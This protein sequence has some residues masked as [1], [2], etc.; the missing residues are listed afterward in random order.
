LKKVILLLI[1]LAVFT[2]NVLA[3]DTN[4]AFYP[5]FSYSDETG[6]MAGIISY[7][8]FRLDNF[9]TEIPKQDITTNVVYS[10]KKQFAFRFM[11]ILYSRDG[12]YQLEAKFDYDYWPTEFF[13]VGNKV[14]DIEPED[15][16]PQKINFDLR[17]KRRIKN[18]WHV[19]ALGEYFNSRLVKTEVGGEL[20]KKEILGSESYHLV[21]IGSGLVYDSRS[22]TSYPISGGI[23]DFSFKV[24]NKALGS[25]YNFL[26]FDLF[27]SKFVSL[28][29]K[30]VLAFTARTVLTNR[31]A[32]FQKLPH[33]GMYMRAYND[34][35]F[36]DQK[37][38]NFRTE[39]RAFPWSGKFFDRIGFVLF[40]D[41]GQTVAQIND[42]SLSD[43]KCSYGI[44]LRFS[45]FTDDRFN[46]RLD[47]G[48]CKDDSNFEISGGEAF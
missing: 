5:Q 10:A 8:R 4:F 14:Y 30:Q 46:L 44:G 6:F 25:D 23:M 11:P 20:E 19:L 41:A 12:L 2:T 48:F 16:T 28:D 39:Y 47:F 35:R 26:Q 13:G 18:N 7:F 45:V 27:G 34:T 24:Y 15:Y 31:N 9:P 43:M 21:G 22:S 38:I 3:K 1:I 42:F 32:P 36:I 33:L 37:L 40:L 17:L 29:S